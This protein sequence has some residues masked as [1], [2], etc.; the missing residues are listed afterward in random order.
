[1]AV[2]LFLLLLEE[3]HQLVR[4]RGGYKTRR[5][6]LKKCYICGVPMGISLYELVSRG[7]PTPGTHYI[8][9]R[10]LDALV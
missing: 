6:Y 4:N 10:L 1:M 5:T 2:R 7:I 9:R 3:L 8:W